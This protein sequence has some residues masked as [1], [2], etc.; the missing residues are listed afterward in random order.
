MAQSKHR[1]PATT[2]KSPTEPPAVKRALQKLRAFYRDGQAVIDAAGGKTRRQLDPKDVVKT[3]ARERGRYP[4]YY[5]QA[6]KFARTYT[7]EQFEELCCL[8][9]PDGK[10]LSPNHV[11][12]LLL[13]RDRRRRQGFQTRAIRE[14]WSASRLYDEIRQIQVASS[15]AGPPF[16]EPESV[17][18]ALIQIANQTG[19]WLRWLSVLEPAEEEEAERDITL[20]DLPGAVR[21]ELKAAGRSIRKLHAAALRELGQDVEDQHRV[22]SQDARHSPLLGWSLQETPAGRLKVLPFDTIPTPPCAAAC[23]LGQ[24]RA[25]HRRFS[26]MVRPREHIQATFVADRSPYWVVWSVAK[27]QH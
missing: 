1:Q 10:P 3:F 25:L 12:R 18:E 14:G 7:E 26:G 2:R 9:R 17:D 15:S 8:R 4:D 23:V 11:I 13:V 20:D 19:R 5:W 6:A 24:A 22:K 27:T 16:K 21:K